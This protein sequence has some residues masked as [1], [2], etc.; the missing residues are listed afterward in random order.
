RAAPSLFLRAR[1][2]LSSV[3]WAFSASRSSTE[4]TVVEEQL[5]GQAE[6]DE[7]G[8]DGPVVFICAKCRLPVGD[9]ASWD[10]S[11]DGQNQIRLKREFCLIVDLSCRGCNSVLG[12]V[13]GS[14]PIISLPFPLFS[15]PPHTCPF[16]PHSL[17]IF[18]TMLLIFDVIFDPCSP[19]QMKMMVMSLTLR[20]EKIEAGIQE[21]GDKA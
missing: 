15:P 4:S 6:E 10:G 14:T 18:M 21:G 11:E 19:H 16:H 1:S 5:F 9:S 13:Y 17:F 7:D 20:L 3:R 12:M 8:D 2:S